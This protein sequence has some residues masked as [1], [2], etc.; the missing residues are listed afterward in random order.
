MMPESVDDS[1]DILQDDDSDEG[2]D[3]PEMDPEDD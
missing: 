1:E 3:V 2:D